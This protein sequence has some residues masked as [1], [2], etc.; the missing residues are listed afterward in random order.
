M[1]ITGGKKE[2]EECHLNLIRY[3]KKVTQKQK[4]KSNTKWIMNENV[5]RE[6]VKLLEKKNEKILRT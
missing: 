6:T 5:K 1:D 4:Q 3:T 2:K